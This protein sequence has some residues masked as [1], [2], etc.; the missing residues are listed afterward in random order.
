MDVR[1]ALR[2]EVESTCVPINSALFRMRQPD[3]IERILVRNPEDP[4][5][6]RCATKPW[7]GAIRPERRMINVLTSP[8]FK[9]E[10]TEFCF[11]DGR[12][13]F[14]SVGK[15]DYEFKPSD[16]AAPT[17][18]VAALWPSTE[19]T[20]EEKKGTDIW[21]KSGRLRLFSKNPN[22]T[23]LIFVELAVVAL[24]IALFA[25]SWVWRLPGVLLT[26]GSAF[27][28]FQAQSRG[29]FLAFLAGSAVLLFFRFRH[30]ISRRLLVTV[31]LC[32]A[33]VV[34]L[35]LV[36][37]TAGRMTAGTVA[38]EGDR[39]SQNRLVIWQE[40]PRMIA[41]AP[42]G[43]GLWKS[44]PAYNGWFEKP[45]NMHMIGDLFNDHL[46]RFVEG[47]FV[48]GGLYVFVWALL[49][50]GGLSFAWRGGSPVQ[51][52]VCAAY[53][54]ASTFNPMNWWMPGFFVPVA[55]LAWGMWT[56]KFM[57][58]GRESA[59]PLMRL[60]AWAAGVTAV[61][62]AGVAVVAWLAPEQDVPLRVGWLGRQVIVGRGEP[63]VWLVDDGFVLSGDYYGFPGKE[64]RA[65]Y[66]AHPDAEP[67][68][69][70]TDLRDVP[71]GVDRLVV[72]GREC[73]PYIR[74]GHPQTQH[75]VLLT[76]PFGSDTIPRKMIESTDLH[77]LTGEYA[78]RL[79]GDDKVRSPR[80]HVCP[81]A[82]AYVPNWLDVVV[83]KL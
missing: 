5:C 18:S 8:D 35:A 20:E 36:T 46:S 24:G 10:K 78:A 45:E 42:F 13:R 72:T 33:L 29:G 6:L 11:V 19:L 2:H 76:P 16:Y 1:A 61:V 4:N 9:G 53:F 66:R 65:Y 25:G 38:V 43:W 79:T 70:V 49:L 23:A 31:S 80:V 59:S 57:T 15:K 83:G 30:G 55:V 48:F 34:G 40:V 71:E 69:I 28:M 74:E 68:G 39:S 63:K 41:A 26:L 60:F 77:V 56:G 50:V 73:V 14:M 27:F 82:E 54:V 21:K 67:L 52:A 58:S 62:L 64:I 17:N 7:I 37:K 81:G 75:V 47:G 32:V 3:G 44:G 12:L 22:R 51:L